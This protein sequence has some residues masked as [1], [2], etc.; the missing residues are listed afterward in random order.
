MTVYDALI[1]LNALIPDWD[2]SKA[3]EIAQE[4]MCHSRMDKS[5][6]KILLNKHPS[7]EEH[8]FNWR[9][10]NF[11]HITY[12]EFMRAKNA[13]YRIFQTADHSF[14]A[15][16]ETLDYLK[17]ARFGKLS[18]VLFDAYIQQ[19]CLQAMLEDPNAWLVI[20]PKLPAPPSNESVE[21]DLKII[22]SKNQI[23]AD[24]DVIVFSDG[25]YERSG[26]G[27][28][29]KSGI[30]IDKTTI[31]KFKNIDGRYVIS[32]E[33]YNHDL[34]EI[35]FCVLGGNMSTDDVY[36]SFFQPFV[37]Y[38]NEAVAFY[39]EWQVTKSSC[40]FPIKE[41]DQIPCH[42]CNGTGYVE[43]KT[44]SSCKGSRFEGYSFSPASIILRPQ[45]RG[46]EPEPTRQMLEYISPD[47][48][49]IQ[50]QK[51]DWQLMLDKA[52]NAL[53]LHYVLEAQSGIA[54]DIDRS[55]FYAFL[56]AI[57]TMLFGNIEYMA[58]Y[59]IER[60]RRFANAEPVSVIVPTTYTIETKTDLLDD[61]SKG[62]ALPFTP[63]R[64]ELLTRLNRN[65]NANDPVQIKIN[66]FMLRY[67]PLYTLTTAEITLDVDS[68]VI[69]QDE[70]GK[71]RFAY[72]EL[73]KLID[74]KQAE[75][76]PTE[77]SNFNWFLD[78][79]Y[80]TIESALNERISAMLQSEKPEQPAIRPSEEPPI[81]EAV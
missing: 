25:C 3:R 55:E 77:Y 36:T 47:V 34:G 74:D 52:M 44:C 51:A 59:F 78:S 32:D 65:I 48:S 50:E 43:E 7:E 18:G 80:A 17:R 68:G 41:M 26:V 63:L 28:Y 75:L 12:P 37:E 20:M 67:D 56:N 49:I 39:S 31:V 21:I 40:A 42:A 10:K 35:P 69:T 60:M 16:A 33:P 22:W 76:A 30:A 14:S 46:S 24:D 1:N 54:K 29:V 81:V 27:G 70:A 8:V 6:A 5:C 45:R 15:S 2:N 62:I 9:V 4:I 19:Y 71:H 73:L 13:I 79:D 38:A 64:A 66:E 53:N 11:A 23:Y 61:L 58:L 57:A 72:S